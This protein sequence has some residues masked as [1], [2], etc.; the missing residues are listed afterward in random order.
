MPTAEAATPS[1]SASSSRLRSTWRRVA[2]IARSSAISRER[3][4]TIIVKVFQMMNEPTNR[5]MPAKIMNRIPTILRSF[6]IGVGVLL[7]DGLAGDRLGA[8]G[9]DGVQALGELGLADARRSALTLIA[10]N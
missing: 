7:G 8:V 9:H 5:A 4:V 1:S 3:W 6:L 2:P 10:S